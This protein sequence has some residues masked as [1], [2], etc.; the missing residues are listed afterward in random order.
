MQV[1][2]GPK[3]RGHAGCRRHEYEVMLKICKS[4]RIARPSRMEPGEARNG[5]QEAKPIRAQ[6]QQR[7]LAVADSTPLATLIFAQMHT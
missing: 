6:R 7:K 5:D 2:G 4:M 3:N 1:H